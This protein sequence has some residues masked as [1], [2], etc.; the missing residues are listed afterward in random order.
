[1]VDLYAKQKRHKEKGAKRSAAAASRNG[2][3][4]DDHRSAKRARFEYFDDRFR[5]KADFAKGKNVK[6]RLGKWHKSMLTVS[7]AEKWNYLYG[8]IHR[9]KL[10][11]C[12]PLPVVGS[13]CLCAVFRCLVPHARVFDVKVEHLLLRKSRET[14]RMK[15]GVLF[16]CRV[17]ESQ[18][19][20]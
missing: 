19:L 3:E 14:L 17:N 4:G 13:V 6:V 5:S 15:A 12:V 10:G 11:L 9:E 20:E 8:K 16:P 18:L 1:M 2:G 7:F